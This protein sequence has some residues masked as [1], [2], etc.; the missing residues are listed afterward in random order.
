[1][2][3]AASAP[4]ASQTEAR[5]DPQWRASEL[6]L[7]REVVRLMGGTLPPERVL[8]G[9]LHLMSELLGL[10][11]GRIVLADATRQGAAATSRIRYAYGLT[12]AEIASGVYAS[13]E[14]VTGRVLASGR[15]LL[16]PDIN[17][18]TPFLGRTLARTPQ[19]V[20][21]LALPIQVHQQTVG[22][23]G[24]L[25]ERHL[26]PLNDDLILLQV[27]ATLVAQVL[28]RQPTVPSNPLGTPAA[29]SSILGSSPRLLR[30]LGELERVAPTD[31]TVLLLGESGTGKALFAQALHRA[32]LR[33]HAPF[34]RVNCAAMPDTGFAAELVAANRGTLFLDEVGEM[35]L[36]QQ[37]QLL[38]VLQ[39]GS[40]LW[41]GG[42]P[43]AGVGVRV[44]A[45]THHD[46][47][48]AV[49]R[50]SFRRD[51]YHRLNVLPIPLPAL[52]ERGD[53]LRTLALTFLDRAN[54]AHQR[55]VRLSA[56][57]LKRLEA[58]DWPGNVRELGHAMER[59]VLLTDST[60]VPAAEVARL[61]PSI[62]RLPL[63]REYIQAHSHS[64]DTLRATLDL[65]QGNQSRAAQALGLTARQ[66][67]YRLQK[68]GLR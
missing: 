37:V 38:G 26:R 30:A 42:Q 28:T 20:A 43:E 27:L 5:N 41:P 60:V 55:Q 58:Y 13:G 24:C 17:G 15:P 48:A 2:A 25:R 35:P 33:H 54:R 49:A 16:V 32:S 21:F 18:D 34:V 47:Q 64:P 61:L 7:V 52:R 19:P 14:G 63:V 53:D 66:F 65:H 3:V 51:L 59:L 57:A 40:V 39:E 29:R 46:L 56:G 68:A 45:A 50:G 67:S 4:S 62:E 22:V 9:M 6:L 1:M 12:S 23:L 8:R 11:R 10:N 36:L 31:A 44:V